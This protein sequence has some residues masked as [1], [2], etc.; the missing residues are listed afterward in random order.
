MEGDFI[1]NILVQSRLSVAEAPIAFRLPCFHYSLSWLCI[2]LAE[3][4]EKR[5]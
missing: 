3:S 5:I 1:Q 4:S 2:F